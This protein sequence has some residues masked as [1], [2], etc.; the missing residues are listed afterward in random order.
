MILI[1]KLLKTLIIIIM[2]SSCTKNNITVYETSESGNNL[3]D[4][5]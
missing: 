2:I 3:T 1:N 4:L 5:S